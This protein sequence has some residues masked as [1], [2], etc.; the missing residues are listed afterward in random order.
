VVQGDILDVINSRSKEDQVGGLE[1][2]SDLYEG[3]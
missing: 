1:W 3:T 2:Q